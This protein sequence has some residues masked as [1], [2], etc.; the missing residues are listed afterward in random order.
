MSSFVEIPNPSG[1]KIESLF[2]DNNFTVPLY[3]RN[4]AWG[5]DEVK[6]FWDD[7]QDIIEGKRNS[8]F[9]GQIVTFKNERGEQEIIDGQQRLTT[10]LIFMSA[11]RDIA[12]K[13]GQ[14]VQGTPTDINADDEIGDTLRMIRTQVRKSIR[15]TKDDQPSLVVQQHVEDQYSDETLEDF[16]KKLTHSRISEND[17]K[18]S[19]EPK[20]NMF[21]A[22]DDITKWVNTSIKSEKELGAQI[23]HLQTIFDAFFDHF[24]IVMISAPSR[25]DAFTIFETLNSRGKDLKASDIIKNRVM[26]LM[27]EDLDN[28]NQSWNKITSQLDNNSDRITRFIR[29][30]WA[31]RYR[32]VSESRLYREI[33][34]KVS[35]VVE[36]QKFLDD[37]SSLVELYTVLESPTSP[38]AHY[39]YFEN[40]RLTQQLDILNRLHVL[41]YYPIVLALEHRNFSE[42]DKLTVVRKIISVFIRFRTIMNRG[43]NKL[44]SGFS[45]V[46]HQIWSLNLSN[47]NAI[48][49]YMD[50]HLL[51]SNNQTK[52]SF[53]AMTKEGGQR[54]AKKWTLVYLLAELYDAVY[55]DFDDDTL[56]QRTFSDDNYRLVQIASNPELEDYVNYFG[57]WTILEKNLAKLDF[58]TMAQLI[59]ALSQSSLTA[60]H[61]LATQLQ[62][63]DWN[64]DTIEQRQGLFTSSVVTI[65]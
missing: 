39:N 44:E 24:Y 10:S 22:Y 60:N 62:N 9:F 36:A 7:L 43:T 8:H 41:L 47:V 14:R 4:Y 13:L 52:A 61:E 28:A 40:E 54:G 59:T 45:D 11:I 30:Y 31:S 23:D 64:I 27:Y 1:F 15:G 53:E 33:S 42:S 50:E 46:A 49:D 51:P 57:N 65:W 58:K 12:I 2:R 37:L 20:K 5:K 55:D 63:V 48:I 6:D 26:S 18:T 35:T 21:N 29:T 38:K 32:V 3:Q 19:S 34:D 25:Q 56:Y 17:R 16:F